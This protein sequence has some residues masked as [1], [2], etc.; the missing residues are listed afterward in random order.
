MMTRSRWTTLLIGASV[1]LSSVSFAQEKSAAKP[2]QDKNGAPLVPR[3]TVKVEKGRL[4]VSVTVKG[5]VE[6][7]ATTEVSVRLKSWIGPL[8]VEK[9][10][11]HGA[12]VKKDDVLLTFDSEKITQLV[13][14]AREE[15][16]LAKLTIKL[17]ELDLP[18]AKQHLPLDLQAAERDKKQ[19]ADDLQRF[20][21]VDKPRQVEEAQ[22][23][24][25]S[26]E[27]SVESAKDE[28]AQLEKMYRDKD[29]TEETERM[30]LKRY[31][32]SLENAEFFLRGTRLRTERTLTTDLPRR[33]EAA[34]LAATKADLAWEKAR[35][36]LPLQLRQKELALEKQ[37]FDDNRAQEKLADLEKDLALVTIKAPA[38]GVVYY[39]R[40][41]RGQW[42]G[43]QATAYLKGG[44]LP[45]N[46][47]VLTIISNGRLFLHAELEEKEVGDLKAGQASRISPARFPGRKLSGRVHRVTAVPQ[48]GKFE[49]VVAFADESPSGIVPGLTGTAK[50]VTSEKENALT[51]PTSAVFEDPD[52]E[53]SYVFIPGEKP[54]KRSVKT[55]L[56][57]GDKTEIV[58]GL[59]E[60]EEILTAKP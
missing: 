56:V 42:S 33:E 23:A 26:G 19:S 6:G 9:A 4:A 3:G 39:G 46:D 25:K 2:G 28:L 44:T 7:E 21:N 48:G 36:Q 31:R 27:F 13:K 22:F 29:L 1:V 41:V 52:T 17:A 34:Q 18:L 53:M 54:K 60:G 14:A 37:R 58:E 45:A 5:S 20:L 11:E 38:A 12:Q 49:V 59:S 55:G 8:V 15:R 40:Y 24:V 50:I 47:V 35:E 10:V 51:V 57:A 30:I 16:E 32:H 43:P